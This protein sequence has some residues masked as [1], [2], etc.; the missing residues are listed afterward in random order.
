MMCL[1]ETIQDGDSFILR[2]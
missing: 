1:D 2:V